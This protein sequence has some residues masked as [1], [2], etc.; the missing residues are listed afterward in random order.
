[1]VA[2]RG[3]RNKIDTTAGFQK[4]TNWL[5]PNKVCPGF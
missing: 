1:M 2:K 5:I 3:N 4:F